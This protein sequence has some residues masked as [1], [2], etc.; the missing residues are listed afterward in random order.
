MTEQQA[1]CNEL[2][3]E[4]APYLDVSNIPLKNLE[5]PYADTSPYQKLDL[6]LP[7]SGSSPFPLL[8]YIHGGAF[9]HGHKREPNFELFLRGF[10]AGLMD[11]K[12]AIRWLRANCEQYQF[13]PERFAVSGSSS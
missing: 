1:Q 10:P 13:D 3:G 9:S 5:I 2:S 4:E 12:A 11:V 6:Y 8:I 7:E